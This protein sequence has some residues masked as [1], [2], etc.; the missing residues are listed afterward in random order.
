MRPNAECRKEYG[1]LAASPELIP[2]VPWSTAHGPG[3][4]P[5]MLM[6]HESGVLGSARSQ[7]VELGGVHVCRRR[8]CLHTPLQSAAREDFR[9]RH[10]IMSARPR[11][12]ASDLDVLRAG[13]IASLV[14]GRGTSPRQRQ[15]ILLGKRHQLRLL[16][17]CTRP[18][19]AWTW[20]RGVRRRQAR[21]NQGS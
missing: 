14:P 20:K 7:D 17:L 13:C 1:V 2:S 4:S 19:R 5:A 8:V 6:V 16:Y 3:P 21:L 11:H 10:G 15:F 18:W 12:L 9:F